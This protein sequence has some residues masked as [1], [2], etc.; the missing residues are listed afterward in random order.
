VAV[1]P[2]LG[3]WR[4]RPTH[5]KYADPVRYSLIVSIDTAEAV[6]DLY[7]PVAAAVEARV[8]VEV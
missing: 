2:T 5:G 4:E 1:Y 6:I 8:A 3:W 7:T